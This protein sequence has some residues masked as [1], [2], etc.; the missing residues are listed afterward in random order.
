M[1][2]ADTWM[3]LYTADYLA[4]TMHLNTLQHGAYLLLLMHQWRIGQVPDDDAQLAAITRCDLATWRKSVA[5][6]IRPFFRSADGVLVQKR[7]ASERG[8]ADHITDVR[9]LAG[10]E[11]AAKRWGKRDGKKPADTE[12]MDGTSE[13]NADGKAMA[14][15]MANPSQSDAPSQSHSSLRSESSATPPKGA[16]RAETMPEIPNWMPKTEWSGYLDMRRSIRKPPTPHA[17]ELI[18]QQLAEMRSRNIDV[19]SVL[20]QSTRN[21]WSGLFEP[22]ASGRPGGGGRPDPAMSD[23]WNRID[24]SLGIQTAGA[25]R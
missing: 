8:R 5:P 16:R 23:D 15:A 7:L 18:V 2:A 11:G 21:N 17:V 22:K 13:G 4:D 12:E 19:A 24:E 6:V 25:F 14:N 3:P 9:A 10:K 20:N 1:K